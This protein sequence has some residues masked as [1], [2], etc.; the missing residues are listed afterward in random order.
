MT[1]QKILEKRKDKDFKKWEW[2]HRAHIVVWWSYVV[3]HDFFEA[4]CLLKPRIIE[5]NARRW[6]DNTIHAGYH[7]TLTQFRL[8]V[9]YIWKAETGNTNLEDIEDFFELDISDSKYMYEY[10]THGVLFSTQWRAV[11][12]EPDVK[13]F[14]FDILHFLV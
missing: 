1:I 5:L 4:L 11:W 10:W 13:K 7:E 2:T 3:K 8:K 9:L 12:I 6:L 14:K